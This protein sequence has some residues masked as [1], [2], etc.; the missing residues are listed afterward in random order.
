MCTSGMGD[1]RRLSA[2]KMFCFVHRREGATV[3]YVMVI[4]GTKYKVRKTSVFFFF[5]IEVKL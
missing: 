1:Y 2:F 3:T 5:T 4:K